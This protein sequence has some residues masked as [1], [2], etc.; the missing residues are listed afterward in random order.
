MSFD[1]INYIN[2][3]QIPNILAVPFHWGHMYLMELD[4][5][6]KVTMNSIPQYKDIIQHWADTGNSCTIMHDGKPAV[7]F[8]NIQLWPNVHEFW[9]IADQPAVKA[10]PWKLTKMA[11]IVTKWLEI[12][13]NCNRLQ[14]VVRNDNVSHCRW[15][16]AIG[17]K[18]ETTLHKYTP[19]GRDCNFYV[20]LK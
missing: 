14:L 17:F 11:R 15:A 6:Q 13:L 5:G 3:K 18:Y 1:L 20:R 2:E 7:C 8:G 16:E 4:E 19:D 10:H 9:M 12:Y